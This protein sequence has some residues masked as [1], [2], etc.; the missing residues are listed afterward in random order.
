MRKKNLKT[1]I[2]HFLIRYKEKALYHYASLIGR[3]LKLE[4]VESYLSDRI[5]SKINY[6][7]F[8][9]V[10]HELRYK[11]FILCSRK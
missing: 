9:V 11:A 7:N 6:I 3:F 1:N 8:A 5:R 10:Y 2:T 4:T